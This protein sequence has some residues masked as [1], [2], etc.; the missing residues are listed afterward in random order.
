MRM[1]PKMTQIFKNRAEAGQL[2]AKKLVH[3]AHRKDIIVLA[4]PRGGVPVGY[5]VAKALHAPL[6]IFLVR[7]LGAPGQEELA[8]GAIAMGDV[9]ILNEDIIRSMG[10]SRRDIEAAIVEQKKILS[11]RHL[12][13]RS[14]RSPLDLKD[15]TVIL[16]DDGIATGA[17]LRAAIQAI[18][19]TG[20]A[21]LI[22]AAP[23]GPPEVFSTF[24][25]LADEVICLQTPSPFFA[26]GSWYEHFPQTSDEEVIQ[27]LSEK[28]NE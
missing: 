15:K 10:I 12:K 26:I 23:V 18:Q 21:R 19:K 27:L 7:K 16:V 5:E 25:P 4:L 22:V 14:G 9:L 13:Y 2:L 8:M 17:T 11:E 3:F 28:T 20:C 6:D 24:A 1:I